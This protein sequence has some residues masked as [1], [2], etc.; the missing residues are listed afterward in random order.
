MRMTVPESLSLSVPTRSIM[1]STDAESGK[2]PCL[3]PK[4]QAFTNGATVTSKA[5]SVSPY[6]S[7]ESR[8]TS[9]SFPSTESVS[10]LLMRLSTLW[11]LNMDREE[12]T[13][14]RTDSISVCRSSSCKYF[15]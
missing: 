14:H 8:S 15:T 9:L 1:L 5:P 2:S 12:S 10:F 7:I 6:T 11:G 4:P 13:P 3:K